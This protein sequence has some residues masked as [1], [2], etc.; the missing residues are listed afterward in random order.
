MTERETQIGEA[1]V[2]QVLPWHK[3]LAL[4][5]QHVIAMYGGAV[6]VPLLLASAAGLNREQTAML[7]QADLFTCGIATLLQCLGA[8]PR[9]GIKLPVIMG[10]TFIALGPM[11]TISHN[12]GLQYIYG[13]VIFSGIMV[14][15]I[16]PLFS[17]ITGLFPPSVTGAIVTTIGIGL[18]PVA[19]GWAAGGEG[20]KDYAANHNLLLAGFVFV[21]IIIVYRFSAGFINSIAVLLGIIAGSLAACVCGLAD[22]GFAAGEPLLAAIK[23][24]WFGIPKFNAT[25]I[26]SMLIVGLICMVESTG[27]FFALGRITGVEI[28]R[29]KL[30]A[31]YRAEGISMVIGSI[32]NSF[33]Y[34]TFSQNVGLVAMS[35]VRSRF[36]T[37]AAGC[38]LIVMGI[39]PKFAALIVCVPKAVLG[40]AMLI[41]FGMVAV[42][43]M[44]ILSETDFKKPRNLMLIAVPLGI[45]IGVM[46]AHNAFNA[47]P[48]SLRI[49]L[50][51]G[52][53]MCTVTAVALNLLFGNSSRRTDALPQN[54]ISL[55]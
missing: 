14:L 15:L 17:R 16:A 52:V 32:F 38:I 40:G 11:I 36:V 8:G 34:T 42:V 53:V 25:A 30:A 24:F 31:G 12:L 9:A 5:L 45:G 51:D 39:I 3:M 33:P 29:Q 13:A 4:G 2:N 10:V 54:K 6:A 1:A 27:V 43:G 18:I 46:G 7:I 55:K 20:A 44:S 35:G 50:S 47:F 37:A 21:F 49:I 48:P 41:M 26:L 28:T 22:F 19:A 23:P